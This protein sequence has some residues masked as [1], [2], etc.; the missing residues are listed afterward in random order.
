MT[1]NAR[2]STARSSTRQE[3][4][5]WMAMEAEGVI[6]KLMKLAAALVVLL[7][8]SVTGSAGAFGS[9]ADGCG[10]TRSVTEGLGSCGSSRLCSNPWSMLPS[11][12]QAINLGDKVQLL[13][14]VITGSN[15][16]MVA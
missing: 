9:S 15:P 6:R 5:S 2:A 13:M 7:P 16:V 10:G 4:F 8:P 11:N 14:L 1:G 3:E 12:S